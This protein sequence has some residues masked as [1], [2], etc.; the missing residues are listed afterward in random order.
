[1]IRLYESAEQRSRVER[2][3][4]PSQWRKPL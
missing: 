4:S 2:D 3:H 1:V